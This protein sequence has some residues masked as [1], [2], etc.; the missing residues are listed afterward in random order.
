AQSRPMGRSKKKGESYINFTVPTSY[1]QSGGFPAGSTFK[2]FTVAAALKNGVDVGQT[3]NSPR[4]LTMKAGSYF[5]CNGGGTNEWK[6]GNSTTSG[7]MNMYVATRQSVNTYFAQLEKQA[8]LCNTVRAA[9]SMGI[10]VPDD[11]QVGPFTLGVTDVSP[12]EMASAYATAASGGMYCKPRPIDEILD[13][14]GKVIKKFDASCKRV[15]TQDQ[16]AQINDIL[17]GVQEPGGFGFSNGTG[18][19]VPSAAKTGTTQENKAVWYNGYTPELATASMIAGVI[20]NDKDETKNGRP[21]SLAG[22]TINGRLL[23][24]NAVGGSS[25]AGP[26]WAKAMKTIQSSLTPVEFDTPPKRQPVAA[27]ASKKKKRDD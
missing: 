11:D 22:V 20:T 3:Y 18:L 25:L 16:A 27:K 26:M 14:T 12:L 19:S 5:A 2:M 21:K 8:G 10:A 15:L 13:V 4:N 23:D 7:R 9:E 24:F 17:R 6:V 1:G